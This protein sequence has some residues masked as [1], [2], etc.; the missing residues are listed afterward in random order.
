MAKSPAAGKLANMI[1]DASRAVQSAH[2]RAIIAIVAFIMVI[3]INC[4][5]ALST[6]W[7]AVGVDGERFRRRGRRCRPERFQTG[8]YQ[9]F[10][11]ATFPV[12]CRDLP[13]LDVQSTQ[14]SPTPSRKLT[15][16]LPYVGSWQFRDPV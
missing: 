14:Q 9:H 5:G 7:Q 4:V 6:F 13:D 1:G 10:S 3:R 2:A 16:V 11:G 15:A 12:G 8:S